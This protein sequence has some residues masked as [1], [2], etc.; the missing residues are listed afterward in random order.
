[1]QHLRDRD[2]TSHQLL[3]WTERLIW[4]LKHVEL[5]NIKALLSPQLGAYLISGPK[6]GGLI[7][8]GAYS[9]S[10]NFDKIRNNFPNFTITPANN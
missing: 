2:C 4:G 1:M 5:H 10:Y 3:T 6:R 9:K 8:R 7:D